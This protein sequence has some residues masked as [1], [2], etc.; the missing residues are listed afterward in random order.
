MENEEEKG[1]FPWSVVIILAILFIIICVLM[2]I[3]L[4]YHPEEDYLQERIDNKVDVSDE[5]RQGWND[6]VD[7]LRYFNR[8]ARN[9]TRSMT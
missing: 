1:G 3:Q 6:C 2:C 7:A 9:V 5:Y 8:M 4:P